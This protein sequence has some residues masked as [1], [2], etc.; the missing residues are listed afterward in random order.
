M[1]ARQRHLAFRTPD[2]RLKAQAE[3]SRGKETL[4]PSFTGSGVAAE[5][6]V[7]GELW[8]LR[9]CCGQS[10]CLSSLT[11][12][13]QLIEGTTEARTQICVSQLQDPGNG[14]AFR[15]PTIVRPKIIIRQCLV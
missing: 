9:N 3:V 1:E 10:D 15:G 11:V 7:A 14:F 8:R 5:L 2:A 6:G 4:P 13:E 12:A